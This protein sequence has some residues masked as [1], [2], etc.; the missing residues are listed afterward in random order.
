[1]R[2]VTGQPKK[3]HDS[4]HRQ[5]QWE[6]HKVMCRIRH[7]APCPRL[8]FV[9][10][11]TWASLPPSR[12]RSFGGQVAQPTLQDWQRPRSNPRFLNDGVATLQFF[13]PTID[14]GLKPAFLEFMSRR[15]DAKQ[16]N[17]RNCT[18]L[19]K[20]EIAEVLVLR[21]QE[22]TFGAGTRHKLGVINRGRNFG[23]VNNVVA[24][25]AQTQ[26][27][28]HIDAFVGQPAHG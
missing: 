3:L 27:Q 23:G 26:H 9:A 11:S 2:L 6:V 14:G 20:Y 16:D 15:V 8:R 24:Y 7:N 25:F 22:S 19:A 28:S 1:M 12:I 17:A 5:D 13:T 4:S 10:L 21:Q 18:A